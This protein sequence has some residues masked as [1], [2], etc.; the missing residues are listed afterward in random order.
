[1]K[2]VNLQ[3]SKKIQSKTKL[4][5]SEKVRAIVAKIPKGKVLTYA[6]VARR[7]GSP[8][9]ARA[10]G[11]IMKT[12][13]NPDIPCHRVIRS[14]GGMGGYNRGGIS[15]KAEILKKEGYLI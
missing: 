11:A 4:S 8:K 3:K 9:A 15:K 13:Y 5:F 7:A 1:M 10:V 6:E 12:N 2:K 14:D